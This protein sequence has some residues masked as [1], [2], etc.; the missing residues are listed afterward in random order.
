MASPYVKNSYFSAAFMHGRRIKY[1]LYID[2][3]DVEHN[4]R[5]LNPFLAAKAEIEKIARQLGYSQRD[6]IT[7]SYL[8]LYVKLNPLAHKPEMIFSK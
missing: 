2:T 8:G 1:E 4:Q 5:L 7:E 6:F 3:G